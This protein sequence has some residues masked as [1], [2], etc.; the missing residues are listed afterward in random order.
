MLL[1]VTGL[2]LGT[3]VSEQR[4]ARPA[5]QRPAA[6]HRLAPAGAARAPTSSD[7]GTLAADQ[8][9]RR[10]RP[11]RHRA[12]RR[13]QG[14][15][16]RRHRHGVAAARRPRGQRR[17]C[18]ATQLVA[19]RIQRRRRRQDA[20]HG[21]RRRPGAPRAPTTCATSSASPGCCPTSPASRRGCSSSPGARR[22]C[23]PTTS[24]NLAQGGLRGLVRVIGMEHPRLRPTQIDVDDATDAETGRRRAAL[25]APTR[26]RRPGATAST[27]R[28]ASTS[29][30]CS[31]RNGTPPWCNPSATAC[32]CRSA[33]PVTCSPL[34][35]VAYE[36]IRTGT[37]PDRGGGRRR[38][39]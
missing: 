32:G 30:R 27:T 15:R 23:C 12:R 11:A 33:R 7:A 10:R 37:R 34:E 4:P 14:R 39:T 21:D 8:H 22:P 35:L 29:R 16:G 13:A 9:L 5:P 36:R 19:R 38:R 17:R 1:T 26:T 18:C 31:P 25:A 24:P 6:D 2:R 3:G 20:A 28:P